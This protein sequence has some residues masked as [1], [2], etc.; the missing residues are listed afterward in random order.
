MYD[1][2]IEGVEVSETGVVD[3]GQTEGVG[4]SE[5]EGGLSD[6]VVVSETDSDDSSEGDEEYVGDGQSGSSSDSDCPSWMLEDLEGP[7]DD[8]IFV[9]RD[10]EYGRKLMK[11]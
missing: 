6:G 11:T 1:V 8:D 10:A 2:E 5:T 7:L 3:G 9:S 4:V